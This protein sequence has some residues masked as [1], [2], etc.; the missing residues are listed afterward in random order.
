MDD[1]SSL[2]ERVVTFWRLR[3]ALQLSPA[4]YRYATA[5]HVAWFRKC[6]R[7]MTFDEFRALFTFYHNRGAP[8]LYSPRDRSAG[9][10]LKD[11]PLKIS[12]AWKSNWACAPDQ[13]LEPLLGGSA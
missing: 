5:C 12:K 9:P 7:A 11:L 6:G 3:H 1:P 10:F 4:C 8:G 13:S 2:R